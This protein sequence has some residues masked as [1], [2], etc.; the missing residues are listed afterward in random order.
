MSEEFSMS[1]TFSMKSK[2]EL[3]ALQGLFEHL[4]LYEVEDARQLMAARELQRAQAQQEA[5]I[6]DGSNYDGSSDLAKMYIGTYQDSVDDH[7]LTIDPETKAGKFWAKGYDHDAIDFCTAV[8]LVLIAMGATNIKS[9]AVSAF[10]N[11]SWAS[12]DENRVEVTFE[13]EE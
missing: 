11:A 8:I 5:L 2:E 6:I 4:D 7:E 9:R 12:D 3:E 10:W 13:T 1:A